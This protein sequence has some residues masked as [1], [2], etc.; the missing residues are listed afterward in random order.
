MWWCRPSRRYLVAL[1][2]MVRFRQIPK[3]LISQELGSSMSHC[4]APITTEYNCLKFKPVVFLAGGEQ[5][6]QLVSGP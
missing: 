2:V 6:V 1:A 3:Y 4:I 5:A